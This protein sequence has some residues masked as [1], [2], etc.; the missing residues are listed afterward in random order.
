MSTWANTVRPGI[1]VKAAS[2]THCSPGVSWSQTC[3]TTG[4]YHRILRV[5]HE[6]LPALL[7]ISLTCPARET[8]A[9]S[10][11]VWGVQVFAQ[12]LFK[13]T[14]TWLG[15]FGWAGRRCAHLACLIRYINQCV[16]NPSSLQK[17]RWRP[18]AACVLMPVA[19]AAAAHVTSECVSAGSMSATDTAVHI[20]NMAH[21]GFDALGH[22][23]TAAPVLLG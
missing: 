2:P 17:S 15:R 13:E 11:R 5:V 18:D 16:A 8:S 1:R 14:E 10:C 6:Y 4:W 3:C 22:V 12:P 21:R 23:L 9:C 7:P 20:G 19:S